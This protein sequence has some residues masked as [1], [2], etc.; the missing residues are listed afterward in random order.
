[1]NADEEIRM[2]LG[3]IKDLQKQHLEAYQEFTSWLREDTKELRESYR[4]AIEE[5]RRAAE[6]IQL[7]HQRLQE[8]EK[9]SG[10]RALIILAIVIVLALGLYLWSNTW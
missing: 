8:A 1:M 9:A 4:R 10:K 5:H 3:G 2:L 7:Y 6:Q